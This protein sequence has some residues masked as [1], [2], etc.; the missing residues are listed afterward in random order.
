[1]Q[2]DEDAI[3]AEVGANLPDIKDFNQPA[4]PPTDNTEGDGASGGG[5]PNDPPSTN[6]PP[7]GEGAAAASQTTEGASA[8]PSAAGTAPSAPVTP[9]AAPTIDFEGISRGAVKSADDIIRIAQENA[10]YKAELEAARK[11]LEENPFANDF[12]KELNQMTR[13]GKS[14]E[15][16][17]AFIS[18]QDLGDISKL[19]AIDAMIEAKVLR[20]GR[21]RDLARRQIEKRYGLTEGMDELDR[22]V[23]EADMEDDAKADRAY[24]AE[25]KKEL[26]TPLAPPA[27][28]A[29]QQV[30]SADVIRQQVAP[31]KERIREQFKS[32]GEINLTGKMDATDKTKNASDAMLFDLQIPASFRDKIPDAVE[33]FFLQSGMPV[34]KEN[35]HEALKI[36]NYNLFNEHGVELIQACCN[37]TATRVEKAIR[38]EYENKGGVKHNQTPRNQRPTTADLSDEF[39]KEYANGGN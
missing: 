36:V 37:E 28:A 3:M 8:Q 9:P 20:D 14:P 33:D 2:F 31:V 23:I 6:E 39:L 32:L 18:L 29:A 25:Q 10:T 19:S 12:V 30:L 13:D 11:K 15:Q 27:P 24:L 17:K 1:M 26:A 35:L 16:I 21:D 22:Q 38:A 5:M 7:A 4:T 34:T